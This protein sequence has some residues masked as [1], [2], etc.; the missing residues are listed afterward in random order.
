MNTKK[1]IT[2]LVLIAGTALTLGSTA[3]FAAQNRG[4]DSDAAGVA[5]RHLAAQRS[6][7]RLP[8]VTSFV[9]RQTDSDDLG[10]THVRVDQLY[11]GVKV[12][13]GELI[14]HLNGASDVLE[15]TDD[16]HRGIA[17]DTNAKIASGEAVA[18]ANRILSPMGAYNVEPTSELVV[19]RTVI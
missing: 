4:G 2:A 13:E 10:Q 18:I 8:D 11:K 16:A 9:A 14:V 1:T 5:V 17:V 19:F 15:V 12:F 6:A 7:M 3:A